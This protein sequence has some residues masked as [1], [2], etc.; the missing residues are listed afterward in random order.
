MAGVVHSKSLFQHREIK[1]S[2]HHRVFFTER[3]VGSFLLPFSTP[4]FADYRIISVRALTVSTRGDKN[5]IQKTG[6]VSR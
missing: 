6:K 4:N 1:P 2:S 3:L 5:R